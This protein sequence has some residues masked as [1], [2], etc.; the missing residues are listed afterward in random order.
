MLPWMNQMRRYVLALM[1]R[2]ACM[3][4]MQVYG[5]SVTSPVDL[6]LIGAFEF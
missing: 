3:G 4:Q 2:K 1:I 6:G 5:G